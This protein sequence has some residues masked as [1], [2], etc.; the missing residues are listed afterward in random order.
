VAND[1]LTIWSENLKSGSDDVKL[2]KKF[3]SGSWDETRP[4]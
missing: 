4:N 2:W 1:T 3:G